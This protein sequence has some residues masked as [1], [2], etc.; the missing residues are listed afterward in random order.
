MVSGGGLG[1]G[2]GVMTVGVRW[3]SL[4]L[5]LRRGEWNSGQSGVVG[6]GC[7]KT[8]IGCSAGAGLADCERVQRRPLSGC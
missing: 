3:F 2:D 6:L 4:L 8:M 7:A 1:D 5:W